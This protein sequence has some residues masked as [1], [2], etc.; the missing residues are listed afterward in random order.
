MASELEVGIK[1]DH[2]LEWE[3]YISDSLMVVGTWAGQGI[4]KKYYFKHN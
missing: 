4:T 3:K 1:R 2:G